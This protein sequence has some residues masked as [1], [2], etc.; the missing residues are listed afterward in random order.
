MDVAENLLV[1]VGLE[2]L[3]QLSVHALRVMFQG[4]THPEKL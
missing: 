2:R 1:F 4:P 3:D